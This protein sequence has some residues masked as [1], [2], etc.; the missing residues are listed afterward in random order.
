MNPPARQ[1]ALLTI[2]AMSPR[3]LEK[4]DTGMRCLPGTRVSA[5]A[6]SVPPCAEITLLLAAYGEG[7][8]PELASL[9]SLADATGSSVSQEPCP[10]DD[11]AAAQVEGFRALSHFFIDDA[12]LGQT[13]QRVC[14]LACKCA[15]ADM[16]GITLLVEGK[17]ATGVFTDPQAPQID[18]AQYQTG[19]GPCLDAFR[20]QKVYRIDSTATDERWPAFTRVAAAH[21]I[22]ATASVPVTARGEPLGALNLY[23]RSSVFDDGALRQAEAF[24]GQAAI[25]LVNA[26]VYQEARQLSENLRQAMASRSVI[27]QAIGVLMADGGRSPGEAFQ[28]LVR[29][30]QRE[31]RKLRDIATGIISRVTQ[32]PTENQTAQA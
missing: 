21:G 27:D 1:V 30:S 6:G 24:A 9:R 28:L 5:S 29:A 14:E 4:T 19:E 23:S 12:T 25:V 17:P 11:Y 22:I 15:P 20:H 26:Q 2:G 10:I 31:N 16:A 3:R 7:D 32:R 13:L 18:S 8:A